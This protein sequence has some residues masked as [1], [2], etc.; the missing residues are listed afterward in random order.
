LRQRHRKRLLLYYRAD[1]LFEL[2]TW[3]RIYELLECCEFLPIRR[4]GAPETLEQIGKNRS[5]P[6]WPERLCERL[7]VAHQVDIS[8]TDIRMRIAGS[9]RISYLVPPSVEMYI[10]EH[11]LYCL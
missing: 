6:S 1:T 11:H 10:A 7:A 3:N 5:L 9:M 2:H 8:S 4:P